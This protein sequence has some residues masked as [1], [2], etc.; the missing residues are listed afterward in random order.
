MPTENRRKRRERETEKKNTRQ[1]TRASVYAST[2]FECDASKG[3]LGAV[4]VLHSAAAAVAAAAD[5]F[6]H[7]TRTDFEHKISPEFAVCMSGIVGHAHL[8]AHVNG[9]VVMGDGW[10]CWRSA[11]ACGV[12]PQWN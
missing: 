11:R 8:Y 2:P 3:P 12:L 4:T 9:V 7:L 1:L 10:R 6:C 5:A